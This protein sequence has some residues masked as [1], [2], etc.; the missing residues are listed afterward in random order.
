[1]IRDLF[2]IFR[3]PTAGR[4]DRSGPNPRPQLAV[5]ELES[6]LV[7]AAIT[8]LLEVDPVNPRYFTD[9]SGEAIY[10]VGN[11]TWNNVQSAPGDPLFAPSPLNYTTYLN[12]LQSSNFNF[13]RLWTWEQSA[14][15]PWSTDK[16]TFSPTIYARSSTPGALDGGNKFDLNQF[17][18]DYFDLLRS[19]VEQAR[20]AGLYVSVMLFEGWS[21]GTKP[22]QP[23]NPW[24][25]HPFAGANNINGVNGDMNGDGIGSEIETQQ[26]W[27]TQMGDRVWAY[28]KAYIDKVVDTVGNQPN[29]IFEIGNEMN[30]D[31]FGFQNAVIPEIHN[32]E[33][34]DGFARHLTWM[35]F[36]WPG[37]NNNA[38][39]SSA[40]DIVAPNGYF[41]PA[42]ATG[43]K[44]VI[45]DTDHIYGMGGDQRW[46]WYNFTRGM[47]IAYM[48]DMAGTP[49]N[50]KAPQGWQVDARRAMTETAHWAERIDLR[51]ML[52]YGTTVA[53][54]G[55]VLANLAGGEY[56][57]FDPAGGSLTL[58]NLAAGT[59]AV[60]WM[61]VNTN[62]T[63]AS[64]NVTTGAGNRTLQSPFGGHDAVLHLKLTGAVAPAAPA[65][66]AATAGSGQV[67]VTWTASAGATSYNV[68]RAT[69]PGGEGTTPYRTGITGTSLTDT[70]LTN[71]TRYYYQVSA[72]NSAGQSGKSSEVSATPVAQI[73][74]VGGWKFDDGSGST[75]A[76]ASGNGNTATL[77]G[78]T[79]TAGKAGG[80]LAFNGT[81]AYVT[82]PS[83]A[84]LNSLKGQ[85]TVTAW[86][87]KAA[88]LPGYGGIVGRREGTGWGD[89]WT[90]YYNNSG[91]DEYGFSVNTSGGGASVTGPASTGAL[92]QWV[93]LTG[94]YDGAQVRLYV[95]GVQVGAAAA[96]GL[97]PDESSPLIIGA[98]DNGSYGIGEYFKGAIDDVR[99]YN[100]ALTPAEIQALA[101][102]ATPPAAPGNLS[103]SAV[104][105]S[106]INLSW[107]DNSSNE[108]GF[109]VERATN[110][111]F[112]QNLVSASVGANATT[113]QATGLSASTTY[114]FR[115][116]ASNS[117]GASGNSNVASATTPALPSGLVGHWKF[118]EGSGTSAGDAS[119]NGNNGT[120]VNAPTWNTGQSGSALRFDGVNDHVSVPNSATLNSTTSQIA[121]AGWV[122]HEANQA[123]WR[124]LATRQYGTSWDD[125][126]TLGLLDN[127]ARFGVHTTS[128]YPALAGPALPVNQWVHLVGTY[129]GSTI[130]LYVNGAQVASAS[131]S[132]ALVSTT[133]PLLIGAGHNNTSGAVTETL[134]GRLDDVRL[135]NRSLSAAEVQALAGT[136][137][138]AAGGGLS[139]T[140]YD[141]RDFTGTSLARIDSGVN[142]DW[143]TGSPAPALGADTFSARWTGKIK[144]RYAQTYTFYTTSDDGVRLW[145]NGQ[146]IIDQWNDHAPATHSGTIALAADQLYDIR[147]EY[148]ENGG[149]AVMKLDWQSALQARELVPTSRL[150]SQ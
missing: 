132:G 34:Q 12:Y 75:A 49:L 61:D 53:S 26:F 133:L 91:N 105:A 67:T 82:V 79:W 74:P 29:V 84:A 145:V 96:S 107:Q 101:A 41:D 81:N 149:G 46:V 39:F 83:T 93:L 70:G 23:G 121:V 112:T 59:Y 56:L 72:V 65:N 87:N 69:T 142:W 117:A 127:T 139:A 109:I 137:P 106:Q 33:Q 37:G 6:R 141:N 114:Y 38:L 146:L 85:M 45:S 42:P 99:V 123:G 4:R 125:Q 24:P 48:D 150:Y 77:H 47:N 76:D 113:F 92:N 8:Q 128:G 68:F 98:G 97:I 90:L 3:K 15:E 28:Q 58:N 54:S 73:G 147:L 122:Y 21:V 60:E 25:G 16:V 7:P 31:S 138:P 126:F 27:G 32:R 17:N 140:Y 57:A 2:A 43:N 1:M 134:Q 148:Y 102:G 130:R 104:T 62:T 52:P 36:P 64:A 116:R 5:E 111:T 108:T 11:H 136:P 22:G 86:V 118:D 94:V 124:V 78:A 103:A 119:G 13:T 40:A 10:L 66:V 63:V 110:S 50:G 14:W 89:L 30:G 135:Y 88:N 20:Q 115:V 129:D 80:A 95:N 9:G 131:L 51:H 44:V 19:R 18:Q 35:T 71:G 144:P 143:G 100:R 55:H 120:L